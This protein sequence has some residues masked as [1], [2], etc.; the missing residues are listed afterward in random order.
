MKYLLYFFIFFQ[1]LS[2]SQTLKGVITDSITNSPLKYTNI[3]F[4]NN[5]GGTTSNIEGEYQINIKNNLNDTL[6]ISYTGYK[7]K[8]ISLSKYNES[9]QYEL[10]IKLELLENLIDEI[11]VSEKQKK[12][13]KQINIKSKKGGDIRMFAFPG[14]E[15]A[16][17]FFNKKKE[18]GRV[19]S[20]SIHFRKNPKANKLTKY[21]IKFYSIDS[22]TRFPSEYLLK[23]DII[24]TPKNKTYVY[25]LNVEDKKIP[26]LEDG[27][28]VAIE[29]LDLKSEFK[30]GDKVGPGLKFSYGEE[31]QLTFENYYNRKWLRS[32][33]ISYKNNLPVN[34]LVDLKVKYKEN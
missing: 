15:F 28:F 4:K 1:T 26:F 14:C 12:Y 23:E 31:Q 9:K 22:I 16:L 32:K 17:R 34:I 24:I 11:I 8:Y 20:V 5:N 25:E 6:K 21:R 3:S 19:K 7:P 30:K 27:I 13:N 10:K 33:M 29:L 18:K 2:F